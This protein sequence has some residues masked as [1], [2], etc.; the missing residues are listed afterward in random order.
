MPSIYIDFNMKAVQDNVNR[1]LNKKVESAKYM[2]VV[3]DIAGVYAAAVDKYVPSKTGR[4]HS[5]ARIRDGEIRYS[6]KANRPGGNFD[7]AELQYITPFPQEN[8]HTP[9]TY[10]HWNRHLTTAERKAFYD[11]VAEIIIERMNNG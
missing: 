1:I 2:E 7:Y 6:A 11:E 10:D 9:G 4:L 5:S 3:N 8:R